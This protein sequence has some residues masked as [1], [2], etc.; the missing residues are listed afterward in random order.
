MAPSVSHYN[1]VEGFINRRG[2]VD[3]VMKNNHY[4]I[5]AG[6]RYKF[7][8]QSSVILGYD[9]PITEHPINNPP[10]SI[11][12]GVEIATSSHAFQLFFT[13]YSA[14]VPQ[15]NNVFNQNDYSEGDWL[16]GFNITRLWGF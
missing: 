8:G 3:G 16:L 11:S 13:N 2:E 5:H 15:E 6:G 7:S 14:L 1:A 10:P 9:Q 4:A 12:L